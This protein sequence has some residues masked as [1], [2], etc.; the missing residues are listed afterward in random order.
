MRISPAGDAALRV[1]VV[2]EQGEPVLSLERLDMRPVDPAQLERLRRGGGQSVYQLD[3]TPVTA[4]SSGPARVAMLGDAAATGERFADLGALERSLADGGTAPELVVA[5]VA[6]ANGDVPGAAR[7]AA[8]EVLTLV[9]R[10]LASEWL[11]ES[12]LLVATR[13]AMAVGDETPTWPRPPCGS[14][15]QRPVRAPRP[16]RPGR[17]RSRRRR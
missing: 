2:S 13:G 3:W 16:V 9:Q 7:T 10:W 4:S 14:A 8:A 17:P 5:S 11:G 15:A 1:D 6:T 12:R